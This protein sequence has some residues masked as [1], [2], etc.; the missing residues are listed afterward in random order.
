[1]ESRT[2]LR[3]H[4]GMTRRLSQSDW[5]ILSQASHEVRTVRRDTV[6]S[7][8]GD[9]LGESILILSGMVGRYIPATSGAPH[10]VAV[11]VPG[12]FADL[13]AFPL[14]Q[15]DHDVTART[16]VEAAIFPHEDLAE[17]I[18]RH[19]GVAR[20]L[21]A[22][23]LVDASIHRH[24]AFRNGALRSLARLAD[25][26]CE[27]DTRLQYAGL[28]A[29]PKGLPVPLTQIDLANACGMSA[30]HVNR[31]L[32]DLR[33]DGC[34]TFGGGFLNIHDRQ[35]L[36]AVAQFNPSYLYLPD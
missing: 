29:S 16:D 19:P 2:A 26:L 17:L 33:E 24:W 22:L 23:T 5:S 10:L 9:T 32:R 35:K 8:R 3:A 11:E 21:W 20:Q 7:R 12:D 6:I 18:A 1:M 25:L 13:H 31:V 28:R 15:L 34:C 14:K 4:I 36:Y 30:E 27:L